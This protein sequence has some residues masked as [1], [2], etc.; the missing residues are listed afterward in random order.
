MVMGTSPDDRMPL[1]TG[2]A[3]AGIGIVAMNAAM[4]ME[5]MMA[6]D[7]GRAMQRRRAAV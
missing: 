3:A 1:F 5:K 6:A 7:R 4:M 2:A